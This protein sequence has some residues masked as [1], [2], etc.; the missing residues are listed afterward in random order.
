MQYNTNFSVPFD[1]VKFIFLYSAH[2]S[3]FYIFVML[4]LLSLLFSTSLPSYMRK[5]ECYNIL[6][7]EYEIIVYFMNWTWNIWE[8]MHLPNK[9][10]CRTHLVLLLGI[11]FIDYIVSPLFMYKTGTLL[12]SCIFLNLI[13]IQTQVFAGVKN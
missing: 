8:K 1:F 11:Y 2:S 12:I 9:K 7:F 10:V 5:A 3:H 6:N 13:L 4:H